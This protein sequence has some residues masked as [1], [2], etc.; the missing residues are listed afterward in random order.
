MTGKELVAFARSKLGTAYVYGM[1]GDVLT[2]ETYDRLKILFGPLVWD[3][4]VN[5]IGQVCVDCSG[6]ISWGTGIQRNSQGYHDTAETVFPISTVNQAPIGAAVL[7]KGH[8]GIYIGNGRYIAADG[9][10]YGVRMGTVAGSSFTH[11]FRL[12]DIDYR[13][14]EMA[15]KE[16]IIYNE[17]EYT[18]ELIRRDGVT[19]LKTR[20][21]AEVLGLS[22]SSR[23]KTPVLAD[24]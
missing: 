15:Q 24:K 1:K 19:Y 3:S 14:E 13:E 21:I 11:W 16:T 2:K 20:D 12:K 18:V 7:K 5:K 9:S 17:K 23:G 6:L 8:I 4:D 10:A 22:V